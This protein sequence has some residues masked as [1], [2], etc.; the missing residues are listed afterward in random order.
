MRVTDQPLA[1]IAFRSA[2]PTRPL[3]PVIAIRM[4]SKIHGQQDWRRTTRRRACTPVQG[5]VPEPR[6]D[7]FS[8]DSPWSI[9]LSGRRVSPRLCLAVPPHRPCRQRTDMNPGMGAI[10][11]CPR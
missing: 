7:G 11:C 2:V 6:D 10:I 8:R 3:D 1:A 4:R 5:Q 9:I